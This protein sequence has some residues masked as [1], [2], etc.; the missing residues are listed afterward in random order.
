MKD[1]RLKELRE[2]LLGEDWDTT[3]STVLT[4]PSTTSTELARQLV[5]Y[6]PLDPMVRAFGIVAGQMVASELTSRALRAA[7]YAS[8]DEI[9]KALLGRIVE[10]VKKDPSSFMDAFVKTM[11][12]QG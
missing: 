5:Q 2:I 3:T 9:P 10:M 4:S 1:A 6:V 7:D 11:R 8:L 12:M